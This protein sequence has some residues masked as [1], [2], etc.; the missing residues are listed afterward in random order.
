MENVRQS[1]EQHR[2]NMGRRED[3][4][5]ERKVQ[6]EKGDTMF[7]RKAQEEKGIH[8]WKGLNRRRKEDTRKE[9]K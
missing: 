8:Q 2:K 4:G 9:W 7:D 6:E 1:K 3:T 5:G